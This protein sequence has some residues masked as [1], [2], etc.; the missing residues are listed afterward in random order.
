MLC[1]M[2]E[3]KVISLPREMFHWS[4]VKKEV[5]DHVTSPRAGQKK[6]VT[7]VHG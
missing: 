5:K 2:K 1:D 4:C 3:K 6:L 7:Q